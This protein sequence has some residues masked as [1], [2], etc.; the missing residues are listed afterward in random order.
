MTRY[1][2][3]IALGAVIGL[4]IDLVAAY[5]ILTFGLPEEWP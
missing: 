5:V 2:G 1:C 3:P 4:A